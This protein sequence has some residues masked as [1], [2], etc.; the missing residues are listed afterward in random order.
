MNAGQ[1][2]NIA[3]R[4][5]QRGAKVALVVAAVSALLCA[6]PASAQTAGFVFNPPMASTVTVCPSGGSCASY[7]VGIALERNDPTRGWVE[8]LRPSGQRAVLG[9][10]QCWRVPDRARA[11]AYRARPQVYDGPGGTARP[12][13]CANPAP[14]FAP[15][16]CPLVTTVQIP[17]AQCPPVFYDLVDPGPSPPPSWKRPKRPMLGA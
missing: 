14:Y 5:E 17:G 10:G 13:D 9:G 6:L 12:I 4:A 3:A 7:Q 11:P 16:G 15:P 2:P 8:L 1:R